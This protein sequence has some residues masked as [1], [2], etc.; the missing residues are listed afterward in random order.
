MVMTDPVADLLTRV[1]NGLLAKKNS[2]RAPS[3]KEKVAVLRVLEQEGFIEG[4][5]VE[6]G[7]PR[8]AL[9]ID[10]KYGPR[11]QSVIRSIERTSTPG[12]RI[13]RGAKG[14]KPVLRGQGIAVV[15]TSQGLLSDKECRRRNVGGEVL[16]TV[17]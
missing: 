12:R 5:S 10:L 11:G 17:W 6:P 14:L 4:F 16:C 7:E 2:V 1:R 3:S 9:V 8:N 15:S 13:Y